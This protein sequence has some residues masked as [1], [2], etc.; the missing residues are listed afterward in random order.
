MDFGGG[1]IPGGFG[2][3]A[4]GGGSFGCNRHG[5]RRGLGASNRNGEGFQGF[6]GAAFGR[7]QDDDFSRYASGSGRQPGRQPGRGF[8]R[9]DIPIEFQESGGGGRQTAFGRAGNRT[10]F[11]RDY[12]EGM[13]RRPKYDPLASL[14]NRDGAPTEASQQ[15]QPGYPSNLHR[16]GTPRLSGQVPEIPSAGTPTP[17]GPGQYT[18]SG[19]RSR[20][21]RNRSSRDGG[22]WESHFRSQFPAAVTLPKP[23]PRFP[24]TLKPD[25]LASRQRNID[26]L[27]PIARKEQDQWVIRELMAWGRCPGNLL[28]RRNAEEKIYV[29]LSQLHVVTDESLEK[30]AHELWMLWEEPFGA[31]VG[32]RYSRRHFEGREYSGPVFISEPERDRGVGVYRQVGNRPGGRI[33]K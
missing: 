5:P 7:Q 26:T 33:W 30:Q 9:E 11:G 31:A 24:F 29:C 10:A 23:D 13:Q 6:R 19:G 32:A 14:L 28:W 12:P 3:G 25:E 1:N 20:R 16:D 27:S 17:S 8:G 21:D 18:R 4:G 2:G 15:L 22:D